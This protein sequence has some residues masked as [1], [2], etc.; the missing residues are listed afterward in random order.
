MSSDVKNKIITGCLELF[1][2]Y[3]IKSITVDDISFHLGISKKTFYEHFENKN[4]IINEIVKEFLNRNRLWNKEIIEEKTDVFDKL[5]KIYNKMLSQFSTCNPR[6][7]YDI[8]KYNQDIYESINEFR[9]K[10]LHYMITNL[11]RQG[12]VE[13]IFRNEIDENIIF[14]FHI[15]RLDSIIQGNLLP[16]KNVTDPI[17]MESIIIDLIGITTIKGHKLI[18]TKANEIQNEII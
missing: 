10:E 7:I 5:I 9:E 2:K 16:K 1:F 13:G 11:I 15:N 6:F 18:V 17:Y 4:V 12:K 8:K 3:G 14:E